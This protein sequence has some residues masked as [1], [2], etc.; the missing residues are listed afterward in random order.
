MQARTD[1]PA[2]DEDRVAVRWT[3]WAI[4]LVALLA[5]TLLTFRFGPRITPLIDTVR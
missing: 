5:G 4:V 1:E 2:K 3:M